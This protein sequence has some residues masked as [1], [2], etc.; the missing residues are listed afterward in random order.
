MESKLIK[1]WME[2]DLRPSN[3][4]FFTNRPDL[5]VGK[6]PEKDAEVE[7]VC[8]HCKNHEMKTIQ[9]GKGTTATGRTKRKFD[10]P[11]FDCSK[12]GKL[13]KVLQLKKV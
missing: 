12:C 2:Q 9:M 7:Y 1:K 10:R 8:P 4:E 13:I 5:V 6:L 3:F 11:E